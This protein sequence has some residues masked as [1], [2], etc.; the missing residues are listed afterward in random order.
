MELLQEHWAVTTQQYGLRYLGDVRPCISG[1]KLFHIASSCILLRTFCH[2]C[3]YG[4]RKFLD[5]LY[6]VLLREDIM[7]YQV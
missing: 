2:Y 1:Q 6:F 4:F 7:L 3:V 5:W